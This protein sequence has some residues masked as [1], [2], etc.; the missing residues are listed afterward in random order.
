MLHQLMLI[1]L[2]GDDLRREAARERA[3]AEAVRRR[4]AARAAEAG[5]PFVRRGVRAWSRRFGLTA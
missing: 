3:V 2:R 5:V 1:E 4:R